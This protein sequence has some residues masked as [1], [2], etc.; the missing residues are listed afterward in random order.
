MSPSI[1]IPHPPLGPDPFRR[2][3]VPKDLEPITTLGVEA[4][5]AAG[6]LDDRDVAR[7]W[8]AAKKLFRSGVHPAVS[9]CV[10]REGE[11]VLD[12]SIGWARGVGPDAPGDAEPV[13]N[14]PDTPHVIF[15]ASKALTASVAHLLD[16]Q[17]KIHID[18][19]VAEYI[20]EYARHGKEG[21]TIAHVLSHRGGVPNLPGEAFK[22]ENIDDR[23]A[24][25]EMLVD[26]KPQ[27][28]PG[29]ALAYHAISGGYIIGEIVHRV[30][31]KSIREVLAEEILDPL[32]LRWTNYGVDA[33]DVEAVATSHYTG[34]PVLPPEALLEAMRPSKTR[35]A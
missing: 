6:G 21:V 32:G 22:L 5:A 10:R 26:A 33:A 19:R 7:I 23:D 27:S 34:A 14:T 20:P 29:T 25:V 24:I 35:K 17:G 1:G 18:D 28:R 2:I 16:Q 12:R 13:L 31:G 9:L 4:P 15:S 8:S 11:V 3:K 30:T